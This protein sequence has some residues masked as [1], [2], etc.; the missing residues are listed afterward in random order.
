MSANP[1]LIKWFDALSFDALISRK[2]EAQFDIQ[3]LVEEHDEII[4]GAAVSQG[5]ELRDLAPGAI[6]V[7]RAT[8]DLG[9]KPCDLKAVDSRE[10]GAWR[11]GFC[12]NSA[13]IRRLAGSPC[14]SSL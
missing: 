10:I 11:L 1:Y 4:R 14:P 5:T 6:S 12:T 13:L 3:R 8:P 2:E 9:A 7:A